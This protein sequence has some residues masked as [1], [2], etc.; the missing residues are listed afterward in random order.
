MLDIVEIPDGRDLG[1]A[2]AIG[3]KAGNVLS[4]QL[5]SLEYEPEFGV[6]LAYFLTSEFRIQTASFR[7]YLIQRLT[8]SDV[9]VTEVLTQVQALAEKYTFSVAANESLEQGLIS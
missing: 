3:P 8:E 2:N 4:V 5:G 1:V 9:N 7:S 6:D